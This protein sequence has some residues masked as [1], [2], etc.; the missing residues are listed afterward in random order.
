MMNLAQRSSR[1]CVAVMRDYA[2]KVRRRAAW[3]APEETGA[4]GDLKNWEVIERKNGINRRL[5]FTVQ[6]KPSAMRILKGRAVPVTRYAKYMHDDTSY[7]IRGRDKLGKEIN[8]RAKANRTPPRGQKRLSKYPNRS[9]NYVGRLF[10]TRAINQ[11]RLPILEKLREAV[12][13]ELK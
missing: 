2:D 10:L 12:A 5:T 13:K 8:S 7:K 4:L 9:G 3:F 1:A 6:I 11:Y